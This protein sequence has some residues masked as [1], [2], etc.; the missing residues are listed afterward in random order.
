MR[1]AS[2]RSMGELGPLLVE[3]S[4]YRATLPWQG[5]QADEGDGDGDREKNIGEELRRRTPTIRAEVAWPSI[6]TPFL[7]SRAHYRHINERAALMPDDALMYLRQSA[8]QT[9]RVLEFSPFATRASNEEQRK[10]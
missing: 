1:D 5:V 6:S 7:A 4:K 9:Q 2:N 8:Y 10:P 3:T